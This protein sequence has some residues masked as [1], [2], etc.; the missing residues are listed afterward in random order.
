M[1]VFRIFKKCFNK[2]AKAV[3]NKNHNYRKKI[4]YSKAKATKKSNI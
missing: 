4:K 3:L 1:H 2:K